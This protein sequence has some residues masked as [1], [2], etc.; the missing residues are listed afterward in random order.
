MANASIE[1]YKS[2]ITENYSVESIVLGCGEFSAVHL[3]RER[4]TKELAAVKVID[5]ENY[6]HQF[7]AEVRA[8]SLCKHENIEA[9][10]GFRLGRSSSTGYLFIEYLPHPTLESLTLNSKVGFSERKAFRIVEQLANAINSLHQHGISHHDLKPDNILINTKTRKVKII[11]FGLSIAFDFKDPFV[12]HPSGTPLFLP[13]ET[14][15]DLPHDP[16]GTDVWSLGIIL[17]FMLTKKYPWGEDLT[18]EVLLRFVKTVP[19]DL[20]IFSSQ[21]RLVLKGALNLN[22]AIRIT[23]PELLRVVRDALNRKDERTDS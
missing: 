4:T 12:R 14:L 11:D 18:E 16:R 3:A 20:R 23:V 9:F 13:P 10:Y 1:K 8:L 22:P 15:E 19:V 5:L 21:V 7:I 17:Y 6:P 2:Y